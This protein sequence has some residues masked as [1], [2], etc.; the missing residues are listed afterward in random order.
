MTLLICI[1]LSI[2][3]YLY[4]YW[5]LS[6]LFYCYSFL[7]PRFKIK[8]FAHNDQDDRIVQAGKLFFDTIK[9][10]WK[11]NF[12]KNTNPIVLELACGRGEYTVWLAEQFPNKNFVGV[13][14]KWDRMWMWLQ[15]ATS[16]WLT[17]VWFLRTII[18][19]LDK[20]FADEEVDEIWIVHPDPRPKGADARRRLTNPRFLALYEKVL[21]SG[22]LLRLK[23]DDADL[24]DYSLEMFA[25][26]WWTI[27]SQT[28]D[29][30]T[31][32]LLAEHYGIQT[33]YEQKF[34]GQWRTIHYCVVC[35]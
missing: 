29:L 13:D 30:Y 7:M 1:L 19:H 3:L 23:T 2:Y 6:S 11:R 26:E 22:W 35:K 8:R 4:I 21:I 18:H 25:Q 31:S 33:H 20:F 24:F 27:I 28:R 14:K 17:N 5:L 32:D 9:G 34:V 16:L 10:C 15:E 12:F